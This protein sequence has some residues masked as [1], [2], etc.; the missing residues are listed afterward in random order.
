MK[1]KQLLIYIFVRFVQPVKALSPIPAILL[2][3]SIEVKLVHSQNALSSIKVILSEK[4][5]SVKLLHPQ[6]L[7]LVDY[8][9]YT[10]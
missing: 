8:Q 4:L 3:K 10:L 2:G 6:Y 5:I 7:L 1:S 9:C